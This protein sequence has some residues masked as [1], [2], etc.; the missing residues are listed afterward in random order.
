MFHDLSSRS[1]SLLCLVGL[2]FP[3][4]LSRTHM[5]RY[6]HTI[7]AVALGLHAAMVNVMTTPHGQ[8]LC[9]FR[10][11]QRISNMCKTLVLV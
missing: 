11:F 5:L 2:D 6:L 7:C 10:T 8:S 3:D 1:V 9:T 4:K